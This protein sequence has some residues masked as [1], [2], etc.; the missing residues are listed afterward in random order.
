MFTVDWIL[1]P[2]T[3]MSSLEARRWTLWASFL[4]SHNFGV[5]LLPFLVSFLFVYF[6]TISMSVLATE[7]VVSDSFIAKCERRIVP[8]THPSFHHEFSVV[9]R[10]YYYRETRVIDRRCW[11]MVCNF[12]TKFARQLSSIWCCWKA[13]ENERVQGDRAIS[14]TREMRRSWDSYF[15]GDAVGALDWS[16]EN[17]FY[18]S[19]VLLPTAICYRQRCRFCCHKFPIHS[20]AKCEAAWRQYNMNLSAWGPHGISPLVF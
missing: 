5:V 6:F 2:H 16:S 1:T 3:Y 7:G 14:T 20:S 9:Y 12:H 17:F 4:M 18:L 11:W 13:L 19:K 15:S 8:L 10:S